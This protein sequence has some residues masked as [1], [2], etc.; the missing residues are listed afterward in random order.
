MR[1]RVVVIG[2]AGLLAAFALA[3]C[4]F[5]PHGESDERELARTSYVKTTP[6]PLASDAAIEDILAYAYL[7]NADLEA[8][9]WEWRA[10]I[11]QIP[12]D[13]TIPATPAVT[14]ESMFEHGKTS[15]AATTLTLGND[16]M[17]NIP[18][19]G[20]TIAAG[21]R[22]LELARAAG[23]RFRAAQLELRMKVLDSYYDYALLA[24]SIRLKQQSVSLL[25][26]AYGDSEARLRAGQGSSVEIL[27]ARNGLDLARNDLRN[28][29]SKTPGQLAMINALLSREPAAALD[30]P[31][32]LPAPR[33]FA[34]TD[35]EV[36][37]LLAERNPELAALA[38]EAK[39]DEH[40]ITMMRRGY[41]PTLGLDLSGDLAG[42]AKGIMVMLAA[43][44]VRFQAVHASVVQAEAELASARAMRRG[45]EYDLKARA[46]LSLYDLR[47]DERQTALFE[48]A[49][50]PRAEQI[51]AV[52]RSMYTNAQAPFTDLLGSARMLV[53]LR[54]MYAEMRMEREKMLAEIEALASPA[55]TPSQG[56]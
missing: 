17:T 46:V 32:A 26:S 25:Q 47:N 41:L 33:Q 21:K 24:E 51:V 18:W 27:E 15:L 53:E 42:M 16:P 7:A 2:A 8:R 31:K 48:Q 10:A 19:P 45:A 9:Y 23:F 43:P 14:W 1:Y 11:E 36:L 54:L 52:K 50:I 6:A 37:S 20:I 55:P 38:H 49:V 12:Q 39:A 40:A 34:L 22:A 4:A 13:A 29:E 30:P 5:H 44:F 28:L 35:A 3:S 56:Q